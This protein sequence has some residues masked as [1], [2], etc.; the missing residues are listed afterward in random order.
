[1]YPV[2]VLWGFRTTDELLANGAKA[3]VERPQDVLPLFG[4]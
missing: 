3:L 1:M 4:L 2:G